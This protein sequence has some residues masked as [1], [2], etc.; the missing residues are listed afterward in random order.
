MR[1]A[2]LLFLAAAP[3]AGAQTW[4]TAAGLGLTRGGAASV[5]SLG[6]EHGVLG[7]FSGGGRVALFSSRRQ[8]RDGQVQEG[9]AFEGTVSAHVRLGPAEL[10][11]FT[12]AG[13]ATIT[14][15]TFRSG[16]EVRRYTEGYTL[17]I[18]GGGVD[19]Y[20]VPGLGVGV[21]VRGVRS[22]SPLDLAEASAGVRLRF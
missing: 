20:P 18:A 11:L 7:R 4:R 2:L 21:E 6:G 17:L 3:G 22:S 1:L 14:E 15:N 12:G 10:R 9:G 8:V 19:V 5:V 13:V 16:R